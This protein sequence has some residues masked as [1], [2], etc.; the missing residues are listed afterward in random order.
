VLGQK[1][2]RLHSV[3]GNRLLGRRDLGTSALY[4][5]A[6]VPHDL[7]LTLFNKMLIGGIYQIFGKRAFSVQSDFVRL[8]EW[9]NVEVDQSPQFEES[10][11]S[12]DGSSI[13]SKMPSACCC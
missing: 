6:Q 3:K 10:M 2:D 13:S 1:V 12:D 7:L 5:P 11:Q 4:T 8:L 9:V